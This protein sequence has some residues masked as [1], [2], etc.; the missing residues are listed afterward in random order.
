MARVR[1]K[2]IAVCDEVRVYF[3]EE[4]VVLT[5]DQAVQLADLLTDA[6][7]HYEQFR[8]K[9]QKKAKGRNRG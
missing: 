2:V 3:G 8:E 1:C 6:V 5:M 7:E 9:N 4:F